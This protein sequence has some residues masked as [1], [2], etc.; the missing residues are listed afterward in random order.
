MSGLGF[1]SFCHPGASARRGTPPRTRVDGAEPLTG[2]GPTD[3]VG[4]LCHTATVEPAAQG[5]ADASAP[6]ALALLRALSSG[7]D[8]RLRHVEVIPARPGRR[9]AYPAW[10]APPVRE[11]FVRGGIETLWRH[12]A[13]GARAAW[14]GE[15]V[16]VA[17]GTASGKS[18]AYQL[19]ALTAI[20]SSRGAR[21][22][23]G[24]G[25][26]YVAPTKALAHDQLGALESLGLDARFATCDGDS[27][28][29]Q[30]DWAR[31]HGEY[32]LTNPDLLHL[33]LLPNHERWAPFLGCLRFVVIDE[34]HS[35][36]GVFGA[37]VA[38]VL[39][40]LR[41]I[42][43]RYGADP[44][45][46]LASATVA[47]PEATASALTGLP[48][49]AVTEDASPRGRTVLALWEPEVAGHRGEHGAPVR[50]SAAAVAAELLADLVAVDVRTL[51][52]VRSRRAAEQVAQTAGMQLALRDP[53]L[54]AR[55]AAY[56]GGYL[57]EER[58][59][60]EA[61]LR[62]GSLTG[63]AATNA[64]ELGIDVQGLDA[65][66]M[67]GYPGTRA[68]LW[69]QVGRAGRRGG[70][71]LAI[72]IARDDPLDAFLV[73]H[74][75]ALL[76]SPVEATVLDPDN[77]HVLGPHLCAAAAE[78]P[79]T[80]DDIGAFGPRA[81]EV[82]DDLTAAGLL[83]RRARGWFWADRRRAS[84]LAD[85]RSTGGDP[86]PLVESGTG[87]VIGSVDAAR[88]H[89][90]VH[91]GA[92]YTHRGETWIVEALDL[93]EH[94]AVIRRADPGYTTTAR[95]VAEL[96]ILE[97]QRRS[98]GHRAR[99]GYGEVEVTRQV[100]GFLRRRVPD[101]EFLGQEPLDLPPRSLRTTAVWWTAQ[102]EALAGRGLDRVRI[103]G[104]VHAV[105]H[106]SVGLLP[107]L[108]TCDRGDVG[109]VSAASHPDTDG[110]TVFVHDSYPGGAG[111]A[112]R[113]FEA[114]TTWIRSVR[115]AVAACACQEGCPS[116]IQSPGCGSQNSPL[117][118]EGAV[119]LLDALL[120]GLGSPQAG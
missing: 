51:A 109:A 116:C 28:R 22:R 64:L 66:L 39:R 42:C 23:R 107:L 11:A 119:V 106:A 15:H 117:D 100:V 31:D 79:L 35:Y 32:V 4:A 8:D 44:T 98:E 5:G 9:A 34:C 49:R 70:D 108:A 52:F 47:A 85:I 111:F 48:V 99:L 86:V 63:L 101:G 72:L 91:P 2:L 59:E 74:P 41:R 54:G 40:R 92:V 83:R 102:G 96:R 24:A 94:L 110:P 104:A 10:V 89:T 60:V 55:V 112:A 16:V 76:G 46:V 37:H 113:G 69:Q 30:K 58:R 27:S 29:D 73:H 81:H 43:A 68:A 95:Q 105:E 7:R 26:L 20:V 75:G 61:G 78:L 80:H 120:D 67:A 50:R 88:A 114:A 115:A 14:S 1:V 84:G 65:V 93:G 97:E 118:K 3:R 38:Q 82:A 90:S 87:R 6:D 21:G 62:S 19:P 71:A 57:P 13:R 36:R 17:T 103:Q 33:T 25:V 12:Q 53:A 77:P 56:R 45:F 18:L